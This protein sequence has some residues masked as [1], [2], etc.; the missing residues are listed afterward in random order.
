VID[1]HSHVLPGLDDGCR[2]IDESLELARSLS[3]AGVRTLA[4]TPHV[5]TDFPTTPEQMRSALADVRLALEQAEI[6]L[7]LVPGGEIAFDELDRLEIATLKAFALGDAGRFVLV[8]FPDHDVPSQLAERV[9]TMHGQGL[10][11]ILGHPER[12]PVVQAMP[13]RLAG[14][15]DAGALIQVTAAS[16]TGAFGSSAATASRSL[17]ETGLAQLVAGD[18]HH[19]GERASIAD[20]LAHVPRRL[21]RWLTSDAPAAVLRGERPPA[22]PAPRRRRFARTLR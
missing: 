10:V 21:A 15:V 3:A 20:A 9:E 6:E 18:S 22:P 13:Q 5:R 16:L 1:L 19:P 14:L 11:V 4:A 12:N 8:E 7:T 17:V 2:D